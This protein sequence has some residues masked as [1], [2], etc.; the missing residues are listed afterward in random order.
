MR[1]SRDVRPEDLPELPDAA[2]NEP[3]KTLGG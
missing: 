3:P 1:L 2:W